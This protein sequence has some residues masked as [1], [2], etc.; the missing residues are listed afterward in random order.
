SLVSIRKADE[1]GYSAIFA[2]GECR[3]Q[4]RESSD[5]VA[6]IPSYHGLYQIISC[7]A[8]EH[9][10]TATPALG[11]ENE[12][13]LSTRPAKRGPL[14]IS[15]MDLHHT[16]GHI[17]LRTAHDMVKHG[18]TDGIALS[19]A[20]ITTQCKTCVQAKLTHK[21][22]PDTAHGSAHDIPVTAYGD[23]VHSDVWDAGKNFLGGDHKAVVFID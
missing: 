10:D 12:V 5:I 23:K 6:R 14:T 8:D 17:S 1:A 16:M 11:T 3:L 21:A 13:A 15:V 7:F 18:H 2:H 20:D 22:I 19:D 9:G 4:S